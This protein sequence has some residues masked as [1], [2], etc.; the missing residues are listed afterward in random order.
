MELRNEFSVE[1][2]VDRTWAALLD[3]ERVAACLPG[4]SI[5]PGGQDGTFRGAM[6][7]RLGPMTMDYRGTARL[8]DVDEDTHT[9]SIVVEARESKGSGAASAVIRNHVEPEAGR[10]G[11]TSITEL[12]ISGRQAQFGRSVMQDV[13]DKLMAEFSK[14]LEAELQRPSGSAQSGNGRSADPVA[15]SR[16]RAQDSTEPE[17]DL[18]GV[19]ASNPTLQKG[20][21]A[22]AVL[23]VLLAL[24]SLFGRRRRR[25]TLNINLP[26]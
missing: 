14:R 10:T 15:L 16:E 6:K 1:A 5:E 13:A 19:L 9:A 4:A 17:F 23:I 3:L 7:V 22:G 2:P 12:A 24:A 21:I 26:R 8:E 20:A 18:G 25:L 11:V